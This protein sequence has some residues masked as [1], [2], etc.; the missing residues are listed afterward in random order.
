MARYA[1]KTP[2]EWA[3]ATRGGRWIAAFV[4]GVVA[5]VLALWWSYSGP[6]VC[7]DAASGAKVLT[8]CT[9]APVEVLA[10]LFVPTVLLLLPDFSEIT[11]LGIGL[12]ERVDESAAKAES[13]AVSARVVEE[14]VD[15]S[16]AKAE[17]AAVS[18][19][20]VEERVGAANA[21]LVPGAVAEVA[22]RGE[23][24]PSAEE[25]GLPS[26]PAELVRH[27]MADWEDRLQPY[28]RLARRSHSPG[29]EEFRAQLE[30][31]S[32]RVPSA[33]LPDPLDTLLLASLPSLDENT[34]KE[35][36]TWADKNWYLISA[37]E[38][39][40]NTAI[41]GEELTSERLK[42]VLRIGEQVHR[43]LPEE[44]QEHDGR[45]QSRPRRGSQP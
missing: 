18:A 42:E 10:L 22:K 39:T 37:V 3:K 6:D 45:P 8:V 40:Y 43:R 23:Q 17:S 35:I 13:A 5:T 7:Q 27:L 36:G 20:V 38:L 34:V 26:H 4:L 24:P 19:R 28:A 9:K 11:F 33:P 2:Q 32:G 44:A 15:E 12:K 30:R 16:A 21:A 25:L 41:A 29:W 14:R 1:P 31:A